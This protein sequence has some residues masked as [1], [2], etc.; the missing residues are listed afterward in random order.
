[1]GKKVEIPWNEKMTL[2]PAQQLSDAKS[3]PPWLRH[4][5]IG[6][7]NDVKTGI[8]EP[9]DYHDALLRVRRDDV[10]RI[11]RDNDIAKDF[12]RVSSKL[13]EA[14][15]LPEIRSWLED[16]ITIY[17]YS[18]DQ[19]H[20]APNQLRKLMK[21]IIDNARTLADDLNEIDD[22]I[23]PA[24]DIGYLKA[25]IEACDQQSFLKSHRLGFTS[26]FKNLREGISLQ[27]LLLILA[28][29]LSVEI[30]FHPKRIDSSD[31]GAE[32][33]IRTQ[34]IF[35]KKSWSRR[36]NNPGHATLA[37]Q[38]SVLNQPNFGIDFFV[39]EGRV[40]HTK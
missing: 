25:S 21:G 40:R 24:T 30:A 13:P 23:N 39:D 2:T 11:L 34:I 12:A 38:L 15:R 22:F 4:W 27:E 7:F 32:A 10:L 35:L 6:L 29:D 31:G 9:E 18:H 33:A 20:R 14:R 28:E 16:L 19:L 3:L 37:R 1:M 8:D 26:A 17:Y 36:F 5:A